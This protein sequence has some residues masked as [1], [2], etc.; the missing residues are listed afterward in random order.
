MAKALGGLTAILVIVALVIGLLAFV[1]WLTVLVLGGFGVEAPFWPT[2]GA[3]F[4][5]GVAGNLFRS[6]REKK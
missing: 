1:P 5:L 2:V 4:L 3:W 6:A